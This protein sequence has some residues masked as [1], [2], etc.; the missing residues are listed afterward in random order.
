MTSHPQ[1]LP[2]TEIKEIFPDI[3][4]VSGTRVWNF[5][6]LR[7]QFSR[8]MIVVREDGKLN[9]INTVRLDDAGLAALDKIGKVEN[10]VKIGSLHGVDDAF[11]ANTYGAK[12]WAMPGMPLDNIS[13]DNELTIGGKLPVSGAS[14]FAFETTN[15]PESILLLER[16]GGIAIACDALQNWN[17][18]DEFFSDESKEVMGGMGFF[19]KANVGPVWMQANEPE[20]ADFKRLKTLKFE[21][22]LCGHGEPLIGN[23]SE[24]YGATFKRLFDV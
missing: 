15:L 19:Q 12:V 13:I 5:N 1:A 22:A 18:P 9:L 16:D 8:N 14:L 24:L 10:V 11:Y 4:F 23:A 3:F 21:H 20:A 17:G 2:H 7:W 6:D